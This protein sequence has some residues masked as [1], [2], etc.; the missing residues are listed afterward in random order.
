MHYVLFVR[1]DTTPDAD[2]GHYLANVGATLAEH[3][4]RL[5]AFGAPERLEGGVD[6]TRMALVA[7]PSADAARAWYASD[8]YQE[9]A[10]WRVETMGHPVDVNLVA[11]LAA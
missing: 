8:A 1:T 10:G 4:G 9:L 11:G 3:E 2:L 6:Y 7:F 5:L